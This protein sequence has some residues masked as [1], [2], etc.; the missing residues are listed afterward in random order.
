MLGLDDHIAEARPGR[1]GDL[2]LAVG[3]AA[4]LRHQLVIGL[5][6][7]LGFRLARLGARPDPVE[8]A[9]KRPLLGRVLLAFDLEPLVLLLEPGR[10]AAVIR[11]AGPAIELE[12]P[13]GDVVEEVAIMGDHDHGAGIVAQMMLEPGH[14]FRVEMVGR[15][16]EQED[17]GFCQQQAAERHASLLAA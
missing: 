8:L 1:N 16:I 11:N 7:R 17:V 12:R 5:D 9:G 3:I 14:A 15:L 13:F 2:R 10:I 6:A 4:G